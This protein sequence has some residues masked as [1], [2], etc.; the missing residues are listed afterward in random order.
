MA[1]VVA[2]NVAKSR[3]LPRIVSALAILGVVLF[4]ISPARGGEFPWMSL[5]GAG[6]IVIAMVVALIAEVLEL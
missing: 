1:Y 4:V 2:M 3:V 6:L 5:L